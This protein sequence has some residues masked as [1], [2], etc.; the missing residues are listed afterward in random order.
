MSAPAAGLR[1]FAN[2]LQELQADFA[3]AIGQAPSRRNSRSTNWRYLDEYR[4]LWSDGEQGSGRVS[5]CLS[6]KR[7]C[8]A[9]SLS[10]RALSAG[11][12]RSDVACRAAD[13]SSGDIVAVQVC[14][15]LKSWPCAGAV[16]VPYASIAHR[17][18]AAATPMTT[19]RP[20]AGA[21]QF[22]AGALAL[23][24]EPAPAPPAAAADDMALVV[25]GEWL[26]AV[27]V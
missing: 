12:P 1:R 8:G 11:S 25:A 15:K 27:H 2:R 3:A 9:V 5:C 4:A 23:P 21:H 20:I 22:H 16:V 26:R 14:V 7:T 18:D 6:V 10:L 17:L 13:W 19:H 24:A